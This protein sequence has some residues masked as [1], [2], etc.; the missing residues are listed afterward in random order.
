MS[1]IIHERR[2]VVTPVVLVHSARA[3]RSTVEPPR[4]AAQMPREARSSSVGPVNSARDRGQ[5]AGELDSAWA[6]L[7]AAPVEK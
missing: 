3:L 7:P 1:V 2:R 6:N 5:R 4:S